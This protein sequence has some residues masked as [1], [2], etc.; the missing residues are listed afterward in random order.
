MV[1]R[2][3]KILLID[4]DLTVTE[5]AQAVGL[6]RQAIYK[7]FSGQ[8]HRAERRAEI[9]AVLQRRARQKKM[10]LPDIWSDRQAA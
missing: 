8:M 2:N 3:I 4:L 5:I 7:Y 6:S 9:K 1:P 10:S